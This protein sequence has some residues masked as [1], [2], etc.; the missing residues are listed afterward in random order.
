M[1]IIFQESLGRPKQEPI[2]ESQ[3]AS[4]AVAGS[5]GQPSLCHCECLQRP[6]WF[7]PSGRSTS[8]HGCPSATAQAFGPRALCPPTAAGRQERATPGLS[9]AT[10]QRYD[11]MVCL[12]CS[13][14]QLNKLKHMEAIM[15][16]KCQISLF[17]FRSCQTS[18]FRKIFI[19]A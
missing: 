6:G 10:V 19:F 4:A 7:R 18:L 11:D 5:S 16:H 14:E 2:T 8:I 1:L 13:C 9:P 12:F 17:L 3:R 15:Q